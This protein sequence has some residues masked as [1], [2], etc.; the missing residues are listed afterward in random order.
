MTG[1]ERNTLLERRFRVLGS[2]SPLFYE[3][4]LH[5]VRGEGVWVY[6]A[7]GRRYLDVYNN[8]PHVGHC[9]P[10]VVEAIARQAATLNT[11]TRYLHDNIVN[12]AERLTAKFHPSLNMAMF[13]CTGSEA[14]EVALRMARHATGNEGIIVTD[15]A[16]HGNTAAVA[17]LGTG[18]MPEA[19]STQRVA[20]FPIPDSYRTPQELSGDALADYYA[21]TVQQAIDTLQSRGLGVAGILICPD[22]AN[23]GL[24]YEPPGFLAKAIE[25]VRAA[26]GL[27][28]ADEVQGGFGRTGHHWW[29]H[30]WAGV[31][32]DIVTLGKPMG[33]GHPI[34]GVIASEHLIEA[35]GEWG[36][37]FN[38]FA[39]NPV[40]CAAAAAVLDVLEQENLLQNAVDTGACVARGLRE[41]QSRHALIGDVRDKGLFFAIELVRDRDTREAAGAE[42]RQVVN[43]MR[44]EGVLIS[45]IGKQ[46]QILK[47]R[48]P[49][50]FQRE[51]ADRLIETL[52]TCLTQVTEAR[53][54]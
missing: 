43:A 50:P 5:L 21:D 31:T 8:V 40:S 16:Y 44:R 30:E 1:N 20:S 53:R 11:H 26:G 42:A 19:Q 15:F 51:H 9:H 12:Y 52:D 35:F 37:Y 29:S 48:P 24:V 7:D 10:R 46:D 38:T 22:F 13:A 3:E 34:S 6:D 49:M 32:P 18:F 36:M 2:H 28:I 41:L 25:R 14:N 4:P 33:N 39:G 27:Y 47:L 54:G 23:E 17:E 45:S